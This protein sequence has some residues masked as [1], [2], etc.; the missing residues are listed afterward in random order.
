[1]KKKK[2]WSKIGQNGLN[3]AQIGV[4]QAILSFNQH[5]WTPVIVTKTD[6][7]RETKAERQRQKDKDRQDR[8][9]Q[10]LRQRQTKTKTD[11]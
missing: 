8:E 11:K 2:K 3:L 4:F 10:R 5:D 1:M 6:K 9:R 7:D